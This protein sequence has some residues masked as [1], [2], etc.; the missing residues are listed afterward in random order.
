LLKCSVE[1]IAPSRLRGSRGLPIG[2]SPICFAISAS[3]AALTL[4]CTS[5]R[6]VAEQFSPM[7]QNAPL[8][9]C[10]ATVARSPAS[11]KTTAGF[12]PPHSSTT[13]LRLD[14]AA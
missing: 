8:S 1:T 11:S 10:P 4:S 6:E 14:S 3:S 5:R 12:L 13:F 7:F 2:Q 9:T